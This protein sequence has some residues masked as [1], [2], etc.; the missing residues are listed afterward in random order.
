MLVGVLVSYDLKEG[1]SEAFFKYMKELVDCTH[2]EEGCI[3]YD[4][5]K[6]RDGSGVFMLEVW[7]SQEALDAHIVSDHCKRLVPGSRD[8]LNTDPVIQFFDML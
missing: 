2:Q 8:F 6:D 1:Q 7:K 5:Y 3:A 4:L